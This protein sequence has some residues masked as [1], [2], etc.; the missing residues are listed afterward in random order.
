[1]STFHNPSRRASLS[2][3]VDKWERQRKRQ[4]SKATVRKAADAAWRALSI[5]VR[6][7][8]KNACRVCTCQTTPW[9]KGDPRTWGCAH[10]VIYRSA[11]GLDVLS[12]LI[13]LCRLCHDKEH[14]HEIN[15]MGNSERFTV[16][17]VTTE[18]AS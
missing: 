3:D 16:G 9:G 10:H 15:I 13:W 12:N 18:R 17:S 11:G 14:R 1:M 4:A 7:R 6:D 5:Q 8:D 2:R